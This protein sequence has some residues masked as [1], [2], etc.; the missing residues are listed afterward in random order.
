MV[1]FL[2]YCDLKVCEILHLPRLR[3]ATLVF[4]EKKEEKRKP[5]AE[6]CHLGEL[7]L[8]DIIDERYI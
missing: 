2:G 7:G 6:T 3:Q 4:F 1:R 5:E 8:R